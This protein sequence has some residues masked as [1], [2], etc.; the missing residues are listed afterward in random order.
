MWHITKG[1]LGDFPPSSRKQNKKKEITQNTTG[2]KA[3]KAVKGSPLAYA[4]VTDKKAE[5]LTKTA[6]QNIDSYF[7]NL[8]KEYTPEEVDQMLE[9]LRDEKNDPLKY[10]AVSIDSLVNTYRKITD[11]SNDI[12][13]VNQPL[14]DPFSCSVDELQAEIDA[15][16]EEAERNPK[17]QDKNIIKLLEYERRRKYN[18]KMYHYDFIRW[19]LKSVM[20]GSFN[21]DMF[22]DFDSIFD[23]AIDFTF[24]YKFD[25]DRKEWVR[26]A[27]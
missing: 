6:K 8:L 9:E 26:D 5:E 19:Y 16:K 21:P 27:D 7:S 24:N 15:T 14:T 4:P 11:K 10:P 13:T 25:S 17:Y 3:V 22:E 18:D 2:V 20:N 23:S 1:D 12:P